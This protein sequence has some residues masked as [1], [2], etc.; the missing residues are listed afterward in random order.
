MKKNHIILHNHKQ[1]IK[2]GREKGKRKTAGMCLRKH[3]F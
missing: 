1:M 2:T 3:L